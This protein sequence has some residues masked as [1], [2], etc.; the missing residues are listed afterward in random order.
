VTEASNSEECCTLI[1]NALDNLTKDVTERLLNAQVTPATSNV[2]LNDQLTTP[3]SNDPLAAARLKKKEVNKE[4]KG[5][6][7][8]KSWTER[9]YKG[10]R[11][12][13][14][15]T[16][17]PLSKVYHTHIISSKCNLLQYFYLNFYM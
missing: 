15:T 12:G 13:P 14:S 8:K 4:N 16:T 9:Q 1:E 17:A 3:L 5:S 11:V 10:K 7:R 2:L 6:K